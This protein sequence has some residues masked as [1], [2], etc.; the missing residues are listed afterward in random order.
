MKQPTALLIAPHVY[1]GPSMQR[2]AEQAL[3]LHEAVGH[4]S[5]LWRPSEAAYRFA[6]SRSSSPRVLKY[7]M[8]LDKFVLSWWGLYRRSRKADFAHVLDQGDALYLRAPLSHRCASRLI[9]VHDLIAVRAG[10]GEIPEY[11]PALLGMT[12]QRMV[13]AGLRKA[14]RILADSTASLL[15]AKRLAPR[16]PV[17]LVPVY[18]A[19]AFFCREDTGPPEPS[20]PYVMIVAS[21]GYRKRRWLGIEVFRALHAGDPS[22]RLLIVGA[23]LTTDEAERLG[24]LV[25]RTAIRRGV[26]DAELALLYRGASAVLVQSKYEGFCWPILEAN[27][28]GT[29]A[30]CA[31][32]PILRETGGDVNVFWSPGDGPAPA[33]PAKGDT[34]LQERLRLH[35]QKFTFDRIRAA[36][37]AGTADMRS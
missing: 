29:V 25:G 12:Y 14:D 19:P 23:D 37:E 22:L 26:E 28:Q 20:D 1:A 9:T 21:P 34:G 3:V 5:I 8:Y 36:F 30:I 31:S 10:R 11:R 6:R 13:I 33:L 27:G 7:A 35:A 15:D 16:V 4:A 32:E 24:E 18:L 17:S 2:Y